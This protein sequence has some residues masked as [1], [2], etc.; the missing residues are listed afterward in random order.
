MTRF[1]ALRVCSIV[2]V[3]VAGC[4]G[5]SP[6]PDSGPDDA[7]PACDYST[8]N[9]DETDVDCGGR[10]HPCHHGASCGVDSDCAGGR[11]E[12]GV[13]SSL[14]ATGEA[15]TADAQC[16]S[17]ACR[18]FGDDSICTEPCTTTCPGGGL[19]CFE[20]FCTPADFCEN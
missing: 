4:G 7:G 3:F 16:A 5:P 11:C 14:I 15:C 6:E 18:A 1:F 8:Q 13:C 19:A 17:A 12:A 9:G 2:L 10:F 20:G